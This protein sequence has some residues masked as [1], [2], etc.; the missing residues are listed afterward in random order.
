MLPQ[1]LTAKVVIVNVFRRNPEIIEH[2]QH[3]LH[4]QRRPTEVVL[5]GFGSRVL[6]EVAVLGHLVDEPGVALPRVVPLR[7][8]K[9]GMPAEII[10]FALEGFEHIRVELFLF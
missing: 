4:H 9:R 7:L 3:R 6:R 2:C 1:R 8:G 10:M 5:T